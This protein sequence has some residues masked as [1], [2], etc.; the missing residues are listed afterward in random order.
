MDPWINISLDWQQN[1]LHIEGID[2][3]ETFSLIVIFTSIR[4]IILTFVAHLNMDYTRWMLRQL[5]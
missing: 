2:Y 5:F 4:N 3:E 1:V